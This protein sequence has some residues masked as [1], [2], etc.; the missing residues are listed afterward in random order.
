[1]SERIIRISGHLDALAPIAHFGDEKTGSTPVLRSIQHWD[2]DAGRFIMLP[3]FSGNAIRGGCIRRPLFHDLLA[4]VGYVNESRKLHH[5]L[6]TGGLLESTGE[7]YASLDIQL[8]RQIRDTIPPIGL[9]G[10]AVGNQILD[11]C[12]K[13]DHAMPICREYRHCL[14]DADAQDPR[15]EHSVHQFTDIAFATRRDDLRAEREDDEQAMQ[16]KI[17]FQAFTPGTRFVHGFTLVYASP[18]EASCLAHALDLWAENPY[19][20]GKSGS[21]YG[22]VALAYARD[23]GEPLSS[24]CYLDYLAQHGQAV[25]DCLDALAAKLGR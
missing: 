8:R 22:R 12:L 14:S 9:L 21:G 23:D 2:A 15:A 10:T 24:Q 6:F 4:R 17:E 5:A 25:R 1:M 18:A 7:K 11:G 16:M 19:I 20:G 3:F 13:V